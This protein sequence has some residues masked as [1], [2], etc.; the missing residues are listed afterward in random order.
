MGA[1]IAVFGIAFG[2]TNVISYLYMIIAGRTLAPAQFAV[3]NALLG[4]VTLCGFL[5]GSIQI[6]VTQAT[7]QNS[8]RSALALLM[9]TTLQFAVPGIG[10]LVLAA[11]P[12]APA[13]GADAEQVALCGL[14]VLSML[15]GST[16]LGFL[17]GIGKIR[18]QA[19][20]S[21]VGAI[22][23]L[24]SGWPLML[25][26][27]GVVGAVSGYL[28]NYVVVLIL[29]WWI[30]SQAV[31]GW[32]LEE[33][34]EPPR[35]RLE[36]TAMATFA[37]AV[38]PFSLDQIHGA[39]IRSLPRRELCCRSHDGQS[40]LFRGLSGHRGD[41]SPF[42]AEVRSAPRAAACGGGGRGH[43]YCRRPRLGVG[44]VSGANDRDNSS[45]IAF[46]RQCPMPDRWLSGS[47]VSRYRWS[48][49]MH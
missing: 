10:V 9:R 7:A 32:S 43:L 36:A 27:A 11:M 24:A 31:A 35:L 44:H 25:I 5:A 40:R 22:A 29:A 4:L 23:R 16:A 2:F 19:S 34:S 21:L 33:T 47:R 8:G 13:I 3:F 6:A 18:G 39:G 30:G 37:V 1:D 26:G 45:G 20:I 41:L 42:V 14:T 38:A 12:F 46:L 15:L 28:F 48:P 17:A 49:P